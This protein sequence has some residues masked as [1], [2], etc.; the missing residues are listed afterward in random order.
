MNANDLTGSLELRPESHSHVQLRPL[1]QGV[2]DRVHLCSVS[3]V[4]P[5]GTPHINTAFYC[6]DAAWRL[7]FVSQRESRH[8]QNI[9]MQSSIA[10]AVY[11]SRQEWDDWKVGLQI[12]GGCRVTV[13][14]EVPFASAL[15]KERFPDY[16]R[17]LY[18]IGDAVGM[19]DLPPFYVVESKSIKLLYED[20]L[21]EENFV[22]I[23][24][25]RES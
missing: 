19:A 4:N 6:V 14:H 2:F 13:G 20:V 12:F 11:D 16:R 7:Y 18:S 25:S 15:Y 10:V 17:W 3:T 1:I 5:D 8:S 23:S 24:L 21:G 9:A 22:S